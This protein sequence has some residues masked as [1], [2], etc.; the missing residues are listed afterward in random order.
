MSEADIRI[1]VNSSSNF[2]DFM[3][4]ATYGEEEFMIDISCEYFPNV[5][6]Y[7]SKDSAMSIRD[8]FNQHIDNL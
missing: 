3:E 7:I 4:V 5:A 6:I 2:N 1:I 8:F